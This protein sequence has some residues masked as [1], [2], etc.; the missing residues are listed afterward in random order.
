VSVEV[1][2]LELLELLDPVDDGLPVDVR[3]SPRAE[4]YTRRRRR[5]IVVGMPTEEPTEEQRARLRELAEEYQ[6]TEQRRLGDRGLARQRA[7]DR[8]SDV[9]VAMYGGASNAAAELGE[10]GERLEGQPL[11]RRLEYLDNDEVDASALLGVAERAYNDEL[12]RIDV[13]REGPTFVERL[14]E[15]LEPFETEILTGLVTRLRRS[16]IEAPPQPSSSPAME[17]VSRMFGILE[18]HLATHAAELAA[19]IVRRVNGPACQHVDGN[20]KTLLVNG[21]GPHFRKVCSKCGGSPPLSAV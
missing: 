5:D 12:D 11:I 21:P 10:H 20:G 15:D 3:E 2:E 9:L 16:T 17:L 18:P 7:A 6:R 1:V 19:A 8:V 13:A 4:S 14:L